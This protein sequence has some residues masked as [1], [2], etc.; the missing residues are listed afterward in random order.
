M[1][2]NSIFSVDLDIYHGPLDLLLYLVRRD[3]LDILDLPIARLV[4]Q[5]A[6]FIL[7]LE[8]ID[9]DMAGEFIFTAASLTELK[10]HLALP[11]NQVS[12]E[13]EESI[14]EDP[15]SDLVEQLLEYKRYKDAASRLKEHA[16]LW[17]DRFPRMQDDRPSESRDTSMDLIKEVELWDLVSALSRILRKSPLEQESILREEEVPVHIHV[18]QI[19]AKIL[20]EKKV[21]FQSLFEKKAGKSLI[22]GMFLAILELLRHHHYRAVQSTDFG[23][24]WLLPPLSDFDPDTDTNNSLLLT[25]LSPGELLLPTIN[26]DAYDS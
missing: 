1:E 21:L 3:E 22:T 23:E 9:L 10:S 25:E 20:A 15:R 7:V 8:L 17:M 5:F 18:E 19:G 11:Q 24:I 13:A 16:E 6:D 26:H 12:Q 4:K 14:E 2:A